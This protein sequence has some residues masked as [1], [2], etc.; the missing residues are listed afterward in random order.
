MSDENLFRK[1]P[2][3]DWNCG[4]DA[5]VFFYARFFGKDLTHQEKKFASLSIW[6]GSLPLL[7]DLVDN[8]LKV[9]VRKGFSP[10]TFD[11]QY[12]LSGGLLSSLLGVMPTIRVYKGGEEI[13]HIIDGQEINLVTQK[14][15]SYELTDLEEDISYTAKPSIIIGNNMYD[16]DGIPFS[17]TSPTAA[18]TD[19]VQTGAAHGSFT[20]NGKNFDYEFKFYVNSHLIGSENCVGWGIYD[21]NS[22]KIHN[23]H[24]LKDGRYTAYWTAWSNNPSATFAKTPYVILPNNEYKY[25]VTHSHTL[26]YTGGGAVYA[27]KRSINSKKIIRN[28]VIQNGDIIMRLD[29][30][31]VEN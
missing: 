19:I 28:D 29:S 5:D 12:A 14:T 25:F 4:I 31:I 15:F 17:S 18:I 2:N 9:N 24:E 3:L 6:N 30:I 8:S 23:P 27:P 1:H 11:A 26:Y 13:Y 10:L 20:H 7:P 22:D 21:P 16:E